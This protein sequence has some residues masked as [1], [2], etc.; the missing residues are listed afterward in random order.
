MLIGV[1]GV[2]GS[3][4]EKV[5]SLTCVWEPNPACLSAEWDALTEAQQEQSLL[6]ATSSLQTLTYGRVGTCPITI[7]PCPTEPRCGCGWNPHIRDGQWYNNCP[8]E[9]TCAPLSE[10]ALPGPVGVISALVVDGYVVAADAGWDS[11]PWDYL[12]WDITYSLA[13]FRLDNGHLLVWQ[14]DGP[15]PI[16]ETQD[17]NKPLTEP[18]TWGI[19]YSRSHPVGADA[20]LAVAYLAME[21]AKA[22]QPRTKCSLPRGVTQVAR[23]GVS[24]TVEAGLFPGGLTGIDIVD[25]FILKW[26]PA[27]T[28]PRTAV[29]FDPRRSATR[30]TGALPSARVGG[31]L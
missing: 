12:P 5:V 27:G 21:F 4:E 8:C 11:A 15:S 17:L 28:S 1:V 24:F 9:T 14:G 31:P 3:L 30:Q 22:C 19:V 26:A 23:N 10:V 16:P 6:L 7:R 25:Q 20:R 13:D 18:G 2:L 29:V